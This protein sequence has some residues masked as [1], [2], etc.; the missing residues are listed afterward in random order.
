M[1]KTGRGEQVATEVGH[2]ARWPGSIV[3][4]EDLQSRSG[5]GLGGW[6][7]FSG[8]GY[9]AQAGGFTVHR[10]GI[11]YAQGGS[12]LCTGRGVH[13]A[14]AEESTVHRP[15]LLDLKWTVQILKRR[16]GNRGSNLGHWF[17]IQGFWVHCFKRVTEDE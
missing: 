16:R 17:L 12:P 3:L 14:Q 1:N 4:V 6:G 7:T 11:Y 13:C 9:Y 8:R 15:G 10:P 2:R 5:L